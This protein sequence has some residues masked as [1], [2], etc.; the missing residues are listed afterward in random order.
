MVV[1]AYLRATSKLASPGKTDLALAMAL[2][3][4]RKLVA[5]YVRTPGGTAQILEALML[6]SPA[7]SDND[8]AIAKMTSVAEA[9]SLPRAPTEP[10]ADICASVTATEWAITA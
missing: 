5:L 9:M 10:G 8:A 2:R 7:V 1:G 3:Q 4:F 6:H